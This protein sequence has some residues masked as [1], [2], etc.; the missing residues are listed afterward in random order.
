MNAVPLYYVYAGVYIPGW[1]TSVKLRCY[2]YIYIYIYRAP[3]P[4]VDDV[5]MLFN[6]GLKAGPPGP[7]LLR[8]DLS[9]FPSFKILASAPD[10]YTKSIDAPASEEGSK[11]AYLWGT[12]EE[13]STPARMTSWYTLVITCTPVSKDGSKRSS[14]EIIFWARKPDIMNPKYRFIV[15]W[16][17]GSRK[18]RALS[19]SP[20]YL[21]FS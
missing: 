16:F 17:L 12:Q 20:V 7:H 13:W 3:P 2:I 10:T 19:H 8:V 18:V 4:L 6:I 11:I 15:L 1:T 9:W 14:L 21:P 5:Y